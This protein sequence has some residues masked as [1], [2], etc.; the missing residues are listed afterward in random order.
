MDD[1]E[2]V[3]EEF[4]NIDLANNVQK[5]ILI[6]VHNQFDY[7]KNCLKSIFENSSNLPH[8][9]ILSKRVFVR[10]IDSDLKRLKE[11]CKKN[12]IRQS[13]LIRH[14]LKEHFLTLKNKE[15]HEQKAQQETAQ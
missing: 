13:D 14:L 9:K 2:K 4:D 6:V 10:V 3:K 5:D 7:V 8:T 11:Y 1:L 12:N 15:A